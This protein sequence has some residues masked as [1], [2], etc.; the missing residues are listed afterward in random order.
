MRKPSTQG[1]I[2]AMPVAASAFI[3]SRLST[4]VGQQ[5]T[6]PITPPPTSNQWRNVEL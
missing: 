5:I 1:M 4:Q 6:M 3:P 2:S